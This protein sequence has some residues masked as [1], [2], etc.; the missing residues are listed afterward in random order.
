MTANH[1][2]I[3]DEPDL[4]YN[5]LDTCVRWVLNVCTSGKDNSENCKPRISGDYSKIWNGLGTALKCSTPECV[6]S[7]ER[8]F[9]STQKFYEQADYFCSI[10]FPYQGKP[11]EENEAFMNTMNMM[12]D[13]CSSK[14]NVLGKWIAT[15]FGYAKETGEACLYSECRTLHSYSGTFQR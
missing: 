7:G 8:F 9:Y 5:A 12:A 13:Y 10:G 14:G 11:L 6:C 4:A 3:I 2:V 15:L 1:P